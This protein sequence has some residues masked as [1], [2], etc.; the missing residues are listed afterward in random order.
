MNPHRP[1][2]EELFEAALQLHDPAERAAYLDR[3]C[4]GNPTLRAEVESLLAAHEKAGAFIEQP[5]GG[6]GT[7]ELQT[8]DMPQAEQGGERIGRYKL[9]EKIG[10]GGFGDVWMAEQEEPV[11][12]RVA[13]KIIKLGMDTREVVA[14]FEAER[15][16]LALMDHPNIARVFDGGATETGRPYFVMELV[17]GEPITAYCDTQRLSVDERLELFMQVCQAVQHAHQKGIIHRDLKPS[18]VMVTVVDDRPVPKV[19]DFGIAKA[20]AQRLTEKTFFTRFA[21]FLGTPAYVSPEQADLTSTDIDTRADI[22]SLGI[23]LYE[24]LTGTTPFDGELLRAGMDELRRTICE[25]EPKRPSTRL[26]AMG[27]AERTATARRCRTEAQT[28]FHQLRGDLDWIVVKC[29]E[30]DRERRYATANGLA[31]DIGRYLRN[32]P[33]IARPPS[34]TYQFQKWARRNGRLFAAV[35][36]VAVA[37]VAG[38]GVSTWEFLRERHA[39]ERAETAEQEQHRL[40][41]RAEANE[42][43]AETNL[44]QAH[45]AKARATRFS[46]QPG[47]RFASLEVLAKAAAI[48]SDAELRNEAIA[49]LALHDIRVARQL[50]GEAGIT[51]VGAL[52]SWNGLYAR[53]DM[54]GKISIRRLA[55]DTEVATL[56]GFG[57]QGVFLRFSPN[58][59]Y[60]AAKYDPRTNSTVSKSVL[61]VWDIEN[62]SVVLAL[63]NTLVNAAV[64]FHP[65][66]PLV[67]IGKVGGVDFH[68]L[69]QGRLRK[70]LPTLGR[71][72]ALSYNP[73]GD[74]LAV[75]FLDKHLVVVLGETGEIIQTLAHEE[76]VF[77]LAWHPKDEWLATG[78]VDQRVYLWDASGG[79]FLRAMAGHS[80]AVVKLAFHP[81]G[82][83]LASYGWDSTVCLWDGIGTEPLLRMASKISTLD[84]DSTG[85]FLG[86]MAEGSKLSL[87]EV[88]APACKTLV[89][90]FNVVP[91]DAAFSHDYR[92]IAVADDNGLALWDLSRRKV[93]NHIR[94]KWCRSVMFT[95]DGKEMILLFKDQLQRWPLSRITN[96]ASELQFGPS[97]SIEMRGHAEHAC[98]VPTTRRVV[99]AGGGRITIGDLDQLD[100]FWSSW[101]CQCQRQPRWAMDCRRWL[102]DWQHHSVGHTIRRI[103]VIAPGGW[104]RH[105]ALQFR[106]QVVGRWRRK[107]L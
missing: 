53:V 92:V 71:P 32:E 82:D 28:L 94:A 59:R 76:R 56:P 46:R 27:E 104:T 4:A 102:A 80:A 98:L 69:E 9:L 37:L 21:Q 96:E 74:R 44:W 3:E 15:Q 20:T 65:Q 38:L 31:A 100:C 5:V 51:P 97:E 45:V 18:N 8:A 39:R 10:E 16:A 22:Y 107:P 13:L 90:E 14:R 40:R 61:Q 6:Q 99:V 88:A 63:T 52:D 25:K 75:S 87:L 78:C 60:L 30:K 73:K 41:V 24:L 2:E 72:M 66:D 34:K 91:K 77:S 36:A 62:R 81:S 85:T 29:L 7:I 11:R 67:A 17:R 33:I 43:R 54:L 48:R 42:R 47:Q 95:P 55:D 50:A 19:I 84:L 93:A 58:G 105:C 83:L 89:A 23:L 86:F 106:W 68:E 57:N 12:R 1:A 70:A 103:R 64:N 26:N 35:S 49:C 79:K 101:R